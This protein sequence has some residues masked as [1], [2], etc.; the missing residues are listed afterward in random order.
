MPGEFEAIFFDFDGVLVDSEPVH[1]SVWNEVLAPF[2]FT[3]T[4]DEYAAHCIGVADREMIHALCRIAGKPELFDGIWAEYPRKKAMFR[5]RI[6][7]SVPM[8]AH[9]RQMLLEGLGGYALA[10][11]SSSGRL[12][13]E[14]ALETAG[15]RGAFQT[16]VTGEDVKKLKPSPEPYLTAASRLGVERALVVEDSDAGIASG[17][18]A[19]FEVLR[20]PHAERTAGLV[21][22]RLGR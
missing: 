20:I 22:G 6:R 21:L 1:F 11:V 14:T 7:Q 15:V 16:V 9:T 10:V 12:E 17:T 13:V 2:G 3:L 4:W 8:P 18:A 19:G 5:D